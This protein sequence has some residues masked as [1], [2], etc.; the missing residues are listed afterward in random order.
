MFHALESLLLV[1]MEGVVADRRWCRTGAHLEGSDDSWALGKKVGEFCLCFF[2]SL[3][4][5]GQ[6][7]LAAEGQFIFSWSD[8]LV[9]CL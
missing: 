9:D 4:V 5:L 2:V 8:R 7:D 6:N 1:Q 3:F